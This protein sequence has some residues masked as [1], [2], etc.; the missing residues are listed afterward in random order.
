VSLAQTV[1]PFLGE[2]SVPISDATTSNV[3]R[4]WV[5]FTFY[6]EEPCATV[7]GN[8]LTATIT[9]SLRGSG[10]LPTSQCYGNGLTL[11]GCV[12]LGNDNGAANYVRYEDGFAYE[13]NVVNGGM[14]EGS[15]LYGNGIAASYLE[16][17]I[18]V[19]SLYSPNV[20]ATIVK[21]NVVNGGIYDGGVLYGN[22]IA[23]SYL[24][25]QI[26]VSSLYNSNVA[27]TIVTSRATDWATSQA[28]RITSE[29]MW[30]ISPDDLAASVV[31]VPP[32][33]QP[34]SLERLSSSYAIADPKNVLGFVN[35]NQLTDILLQAVA[36]IKKAFGPLP[37]KRLT[38]VEDEEGLRALF[39]FVAFPGTLDD[40]QKCLDV[41]DRDWW[42]KNARTF[43]T[44]LNFDFELA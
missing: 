15:V 26:K 21:S 4:E 6:S 1:P 17:Q 33:K 27:A 13:S 11:G 18:K 39:C 10:T 2:R 36:P 28:L 38:I 9:D 35:E 20:A 16:K 42:L 44:K 37:S 30:H 34:T 5:N 29:K 43:G 40:A 8:S 41:F 22:N 25:K 23:A 31:A 19:S 12:L 24:E 14:Y 32:Q 3:G 7:A